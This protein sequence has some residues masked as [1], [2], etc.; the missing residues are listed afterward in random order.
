VAATSFGAGLA[1]AVVFPLV[2]VLWNPLPSRQNRLI[3]VYGFVALAVVALYLVSLVDLGAG[4]FDRRSTSLLGGLSDISTTLWAF[5]QLFSIGFS[6]LFWGPL[7]VGKISLVQGDS[8]L[9]VAPLI[10]LFIALPLLV[11]GFVVSGVNERRR[12]LA[13]SLL[14]CAAYGLIAYARSGGWFAIHPEAYRYHYL[15]PALVAIVFCLILSKLFDRLPERLVKQGRVWFII[16]LILVIVPF[17]LGPISVVKE[18]QLLKQKKQLKE[19]MQMIENAL[20]NSPDQTKVYIAN[21]PFQV[22]PWGYTPQHFPGLAALFVMSYP[23]NTVDG[24]QVYFLEESEDIVQMVQAKKGTRI[25]E[26]VIQAPK[27]SQ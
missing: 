20:E 12:L 4:G 26:L 2:I 17:Y 14:P 13:L 1:S 23:S 6:V 18:S 8:L 22:F 11:F 9:W 21:K 7:I 5:S 15:A 19:S 24:K 16:W 3:A 25:S 10:A 27:V